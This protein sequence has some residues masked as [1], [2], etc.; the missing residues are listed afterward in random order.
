MKILP[1]HGLMSVLLLSLLAL[2]GCGALATHQAAEA[3]WTEHPEWAQVFARHGV[4]GSILIYDERENRFHAFDAARCRQR[5]IPASTFKIANTLIGLET[6]VIADEHF[7]LKWDGQRRMSPDWNRDLTMRE[8]FRVS[9]VW[10]YQ[11]VARRIGP[12]RMAAWLKRLDYGNAQSTPQIDTFWLEGDLR[13]SQAEQIGFLRRL[14]H[15]RL[16]LSPR[17]MALTRQVMEI[18]RTPEGVLRGKTGWAVRV[19]RQVGWFVGWAERPGR[20]VYFATNIE[21][22]RPGMQD[23]PARL[24]IT[25]EILAQMGMNI[26]Q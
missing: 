4:K 6:G 11:E 15:D 5:F 9:A 24:A 7:M 8:A 2:A 3:P 21:S 1:S 20:T 25:R 14:K 12:E 26:S 13:I 19:P 23:A 18:E 10:Y 16:P 22:D 17:S